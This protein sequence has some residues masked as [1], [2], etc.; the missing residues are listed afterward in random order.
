MRIGGLCPITPPPHR[1]TP[2]T[3]GNSPGQLSFDPTLFLCPLAPLPPSNESFSF[4]LNSSRGRALSLSL[5]L[6]CTGSTGRQLL[7]RRRLSQPS[8][9]G[10]PLRERP[11]GEQDRH[12]LLRVRARDS[13]PIPARPSLPFIPSR[14]PP[15]AQPP[16]WPTFDPTTHHRLHTCLVPASGRGPWR[17]ST[18]SPPATPRTWRAPLRSA[19]SRPR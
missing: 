16:P 17:R 2:A 9:P 12:V 15:N 5:Y 18:P 11:R 6:S 10:G 8:Q 13:S 4:L 19:A 7:H 3:P 14:L 1:C